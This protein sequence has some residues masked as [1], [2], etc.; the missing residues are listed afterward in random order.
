MFGWL[1]GKRSS[2]KTASTFVEAT[3]GGWN[4]L[5]ATVATDG[6]SQEGFVKEQLERA[7]LYAL[8]NH[9]AIGES[10]EFTIDEIPVGLKSPHEIVFGM[11]MRAN[12]YG[13]M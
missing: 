12:D 4:D 9:I 6:G 7:R 3:G 8:E 10:F 2:K 5:P 11:M 1:F 13:L